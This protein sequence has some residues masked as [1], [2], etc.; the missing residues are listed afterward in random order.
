LN[1]SLDWYLKTYFYYGGVAKVIP[2]YFF[3]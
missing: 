2:P 3:Y 1:I